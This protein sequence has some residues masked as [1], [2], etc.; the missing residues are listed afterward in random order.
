MYGNLINSYT[1]PLSLGVFF[2]ICL[3]AM[4]F[5]FLL[6]S[7]LAALAVIA[8]AIP[9]PEAHD[10]SNLAGTSPEGG[11][12]KQRL[13]SDG[14]GNGDGSSNIIPGEFDVANAGL[15]VTVDISFPPVD[16]RQRDVTDSI[17]RLTNRLRAYHPTDTLHGMEMY[18]VNQVAT[19]IT[20]TQ[21]MPTLKFEDAV[22]VGVAL[23]SYVQT[24]HMYRMIGFS[25]LED[26]GTKIGTGGIIHVRTGENTVTLPEGETISLEQ[27]LS[28]NS[29]IGQDT[30]AKLSIDRRR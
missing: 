7:L 25:L 13:S 26:D 2:C 29:T 22:E 21:Y 18:P 6:A 14:S 9:I 19:Y 28:Q 3:E 8:T 27:F 15:H 1:A 12:T 20:P 4:A 11:E 16:F 23:L 24:W 10:P 30:I 17:T 5:R